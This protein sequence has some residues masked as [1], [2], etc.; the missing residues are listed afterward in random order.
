MHKLKITC[1]Q[2]SKELDQI[3]ILIVNLHIFLIQFS[4]YTC[5]IYASKAFNVSDTSQKIDVE[6]KF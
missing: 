1:I 2:Y 5:S 6:E 4:T 3:L